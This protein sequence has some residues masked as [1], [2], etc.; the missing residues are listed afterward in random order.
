MAKFLDDV[1]T[2]EL[3][4]VLVYEVLEVFSRFQNI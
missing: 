4:G 1:F 2:Q 3:I